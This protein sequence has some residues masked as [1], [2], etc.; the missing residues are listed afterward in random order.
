MATRRSL[1][2]DLSRFISAMEAAP[3]VAGE[4][5]KTGLHDVLDDWRRESTDL[6]P[7]DKGT[8][9]RGIDTHVDG[10]GINLDGEVT[11][12]AVEVASRGKWAGR[13]FNYAYWLHEVYPEKHGPAFKNPTTDGTIPEFLDK[14]ADR[15]DE[16]WVRQIEAEIEGALRRK[17]W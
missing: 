17:G 2:I 7:L 9:R 14:P 12:A 11:A 4:A 13:R 3:E 6:A 1:E 5:A 10:E 8:L 16:K 15:N